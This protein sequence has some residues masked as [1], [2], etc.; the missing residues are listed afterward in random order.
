MDQLGKQISSNSQAMGINLNSGGGGASGISSAEV[1]KLEQQIQELKAQ[2]S[3]KTK[4][5]QSSQSANESLK[6]QFQKIQIQNFDLQK[7]GDLSR[8]KLESMITVLKKRNLFESVI[9]EINGGVMPEQQ[10]DGSGSQIFDTVFGNAG[11]TILEEY[12][13]KVEEQTKELSELSIQLKQLQND[14]QQL[15]E[16]AD[17]DLKLLE[18][19]S[20]EI[21]KQKR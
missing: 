20:A 9:K 8:Y 4:E 12:Q 13:L 15:I 11:P 14:N 19:K 18:S 1:K 10:D 21:E 17:T 2:L 16:Q 7:D 3:G 5:L 6:D